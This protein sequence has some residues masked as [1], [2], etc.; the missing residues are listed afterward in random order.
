MYSVF[1][2]TKEQYDVIKNYPVSMIYTDNRSLLKED[3]N[4]YYQV[5]RYP[6]ERKLPQNILI[7]DLGC[8]LETQGK[9]IVTDTNLN[10]ANSL[11]IENLLS[12]G[13]SK[14]T[15]SLECTLNELKFL[16]KAS[17][18]PLEVI[19]YGRPEVMLLK[20]HPLIKENG[21]ELEDY[22][23]KKYPILVDQEKHVHIYQYEVMNKLNLQKDYEALG[24]HHFRLQFIFE[25]K[26]EV[27][28]IMDKIY[29]L[30]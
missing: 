26:E 17:E 24:I 20:N 21:Y 28:K 12:L 2:H 8:L 27:T 3:K 22:E 4:I 9:N 30:E 1:V 5:P 6:H 14:I 16:N 19:L 23:K 29:H 11:A 18:Y 10:V 15:L 13:V 7:Q 25:T